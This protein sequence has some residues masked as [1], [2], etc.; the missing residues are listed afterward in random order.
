MKEIL[1]ERKLVQDAQH[2]EAQ[3]E[4]TVRTSPVKDCMGMSLNECSLWMDKLELERLTQLRTFTRPQSL[5]QL[6]ASNSADT[7]AELADLLRDNARLRRQN[8]A[9]R[10]ASASSARSGPVLSGLKI[11]E[12]TQ[13][14]PPAAAVEAVPATVSV[15]PPGP[16]DF[17]GATAIIA[18]LP[19][20][21]GGFTASLLDT[22]GV[23]KRG[24]FVIKKSNP[25][26]GTYMRVYGLP[27]HHLKCTLRGYRT[28]RG[29]FRG[30]TVYTGFKKTW[31]GKSSFNT[32]YIPD[33]G[34]GEFD[35]I[36]CRDK[37]TG[38]V[39]HFRTVP[40]APASHD[41]PLSR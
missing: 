37:D 36:T 1:K 5:L 11:D 9:L 7:G 33:G 25:Y 16:K 34:V 35:L 4:K 41:Y 6:H 13:G 12:S 40:L 20:G 31:T 38:E 22:E 27:N 14:G 10:A 28:E 18:R 32:G 23:E 26:G 15:P 30:A 24:S 2:R 29:Q 39:Q 19:A 8:R 17:N 3:A 21:Q